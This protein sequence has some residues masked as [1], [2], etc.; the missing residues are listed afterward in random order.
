MNFLVS[1]GKA[2]QGNNPIQF[3]EFFEIRM[4]PKIGV[5]YPPNHPF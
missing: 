2:Q 1:D 4:F 3:T 5:G